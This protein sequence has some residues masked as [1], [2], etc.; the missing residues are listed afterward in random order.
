MAPRWRVPSPRPQ[1]LGQ[2]DLRRAVRRREAEQQRTQQRY[3]SREA[4]D[5]CVGVK[6]QRLGNDGERQ[7]RHDHRDAPAREEQRQAPSHRSQHD[8]LDQILQHQPR[9]AGAECRTYRQ[10]P[11]ARGASHHQQVADVRARNQQDERD[12]HGQRHQGTFVLCPKVRQPF[13][14]RQQFHLH[15]LVV[16]RHQVGLRV[17][18]LTEEA[19]QLCS[20]LRRADARLHPRNH[21]LGSARA[22]GDPQVS[23]VL[24]RQAEESGR[25]DADDREHPPV[26]GHRTTY[27]T[28]TP[29][30]PRAPE[31][32]AHNGHAIV[33]GLRHPADDWRDPEIAKERLRDS[34]DAASRF[35]A[36]V[37]VNRGTLEGSEAGNLR[38][39]S[40]VRSDVVEHGRRERVG[41]LLH[42][43]SNRHCP[44]LDELVG[45]PHRQR[46]KQQSVDEA[47]ERGVGADPE[48]QRERNDD[49][50]SRALREHPACVAHVLRKHVQQRH[51]ALIAVGLPERLRLPEPSDR[52]SPGVRR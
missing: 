41:R 22:R 19:L 49:G 1:C 28:R 46:A 29:V 30:E 7:H 3:A 36:A 8:A 4:E 47:E 17:C 13:A 45:L 21:Q 10:L 11:S 16:P 38:Q 2:V 42:S 35:R 27:S 23:G 37:D 6:R 43:K 39:D 18:E 31:T 48:R 26:D 40:V 5:S 44:Y 14:G 12:Q 51:A 24:D 34:L 52:V 25:C 33:G 20:C 32:V 9:A 50:E 15:Q